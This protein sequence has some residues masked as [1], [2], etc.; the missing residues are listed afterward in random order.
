MAHTKNLSMKM[1]RQRRREI[2][3]SRRQFLAT[4][5]SQSLRIV[6][7]IEGRC[8]NQIGVLQTITAWL[9][10]RG[11]LVLLPY[12]SIKQNGDFEATVVF[13]ATQQVFETIKGTAPGQLRDLSPAVYELPCTNPA[14]VSAALLD[15]PEGN[16]AIMAA[17]LDLLAGRGIDITEISCGGF[18]A[19]HTA[20]RFVTLTMLVSFP[21]TLKPSDVQDDLDRMI[22][23]HGDG[24]AEVTSGT[25]FFLGTRPW[26]WMVRN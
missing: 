22:A 21:P 16:S 4:S 18:P 12:G 11:G 13:E 14:T 3:R 25:D 17:I 8:P 10:S 2:L 1:R 9:E 26:W 20:T 7:K 15:D 5:N 24:F 19:P 6:G 23:S